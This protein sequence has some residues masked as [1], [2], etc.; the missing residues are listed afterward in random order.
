MTSWGSAGQLKAMT[1]DMFRAIAGRGYDPATDFVA[2]QNADGSASGHYLSAPTYFS[3]DGFW[4]RS[5]DGA[6][7]GPIRVNYLIVT[8][9]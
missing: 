6:G 4:C 2:F 3:G 9:A 1:D 5:M 7:S 8:S